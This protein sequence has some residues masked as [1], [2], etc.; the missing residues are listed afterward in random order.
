MTVLA[1][2]LSARV[3]G[4]LSRQ[5]RPISQEKNDRRSETRKAGNWTRDGLLKKMREIV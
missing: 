2:E 4:A 5:H 1:A 3:Q